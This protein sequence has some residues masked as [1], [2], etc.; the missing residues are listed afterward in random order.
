MHSSQDPVLA[1]PGI[2][3]G[4]I[5]DY[6]SPEIASFYDAVFTMLF[7]R[8]AIPPGAEFLDVGCGTCVHALRLVRRSACVTGVD[9]SATALR[10][11]TE[12]VAQTDPRALIRLCQGDACALPI[13]DESCRYV[14]CWGVLMHIEAVERAIEELSRVLTPGGWLIIGESNM[15]SC[16]SLARRWLSA[17]RMGQPGA[18]RRTPAGMEYRRPVAGG[19]LLDREV[20]I[21]WLAERLRSHGVHLDARLAGQFT[22][23]YVKLPWPWLR[24]AVHT[25]NHWW[26]QH[27]QQPAPAFGNILIFRKPAQL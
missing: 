6:R 13:R 26:F 17:I 5:R 25:W 15:A 11:G 16:Q 14:L 7:A 12:T 1:D 27:V 10:L 22:E 21:R 23:L 8:L 20:D 3:E 9:A 4:W 24:A 18:V 2:H 19:M